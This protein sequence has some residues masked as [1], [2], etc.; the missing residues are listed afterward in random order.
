MWRRQMR[1]E[2]RG[3]GD[4]W[5]AF[6]HTEGAFD[7]AAN[8]GRKADA[9]LR[10]HCISDK[11]APRFFMERNGMTGESLSK[12]S[13]SVRTRSSRGGSAQQI[14]DAFAGTSDTA[15]MNCLC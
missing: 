5:L 8:V 11:P 2:W 3:T 13:Q 4:S 1:R 10:R 6:L 9:I 12:I 15:P 14:L 7:R